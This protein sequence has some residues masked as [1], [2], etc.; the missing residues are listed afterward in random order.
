MLDFNGLWKHE[1]IQHALIL[2]WGWVAR[3][4]C[5]WLALGK[6]DPNFPSEKF[7]LGQQN[8]QKLT[9]HFRH[10]QLLIDLLRAQSEARDVAYFWSWLEELV[11]IESAFPTT[12]NYNV[13]VLVFFNPSI[14][15]SIYCFKMLCYVVCCIHMFITHVVQS[16]DFNTKILIDWL[17]D[18]LID[19]Q[20]CTNSS[21]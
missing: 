19:H 2:N 12:L 5:R 3:L 16:H 1:K 4:C 15:L 18:W 21:F 11:D 9:T 7:P 13:Q 17:I 6:S 8:D 14:D 10:L 20:C